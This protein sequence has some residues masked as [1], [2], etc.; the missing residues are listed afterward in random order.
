MLLLR[1]MRWMSLKLVWVAVLLPPQLRPPSPPAALSGLHAA[2]AGA[3]VDPLPPMAAPAALALG[4]SAGDLATGVN[5][6]DIDGVDAREERATDA[7]TSSSLLLRWEPRGWTGL[8][9]AA[10]AHGR[11]CCCAS[12]CCW[13]IGGWWPPDMM[14]SSHE[15][16]CAL[17]SVLRLSCALMRASSSWWLNGLVM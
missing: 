10:A 15:C 8:P 11:P 1:P 5:A 4:D 12:C 14:S 7:M 17:C 2:Q 6:G 16:S 9:A 3:A 13:L